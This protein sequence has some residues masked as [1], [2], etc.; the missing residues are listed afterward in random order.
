MGDTAYD[1]GLGRAYLFFPA[2]QFI[3]S[4]QCNK[5]TCRD[6]PIKLDSLP[7]LLWHNEY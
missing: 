2:S 1:P 5:S 4:F 7:L 6:R 3:A